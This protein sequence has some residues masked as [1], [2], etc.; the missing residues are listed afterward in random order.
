MG[1]MSAETI[2]A[3][4]ANGG[5][6]VLLALVLWGAYKLASGALARAAE[7]FVAYAGKLLETQGEIRDSLHDLNAKF[8]D[9][10]ERQKVASGKLDRIERKLGRDTP[11][12]FA[13]GED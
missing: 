9:G 8:A 12:D 10:I 7:W 13:P 6:L 3:I 1:D 4:A 5:A 2:T 11:K